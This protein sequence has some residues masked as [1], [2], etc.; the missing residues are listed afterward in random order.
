MVRVNVKTIVVKIEAV[1]LVERAVLEEVIELDTAPGLRSKLRNRTR[2]RSNIIT[3]LIYLRAAVS[4]VRPVG[5]NS[6]YSRL[7]ALRIRQLR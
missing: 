5:R 1:Y 6:Y 7:A 2:Y 3:I 4:I